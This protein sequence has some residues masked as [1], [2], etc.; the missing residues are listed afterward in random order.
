MKCPTTRPCVAVV[1]EI[2]YYLTLI[3]PK[4]CSDNLVIW[5]TNPWKKKQVLVPR[6]SPRDYVQGAKPSHE[7]QIHCKIAPE[8]DTP[9][10]KT[11]LF[12]LAQARWKRNTNNK[13]QS[14]HPQLGCFVM[15]TVS[16]TSWPLQHPTQNANVILK[17]N[18]HPLFVSKRHNWYHVRSRSGTNC[19][20]ISQQQSL[21]ERQSW[22]RQAKYR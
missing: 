18:K 2:E 4:W 9:F 13:L 8:S 22:L 15:H 10:L 17:F 7:E 19:Q 3:P 11:V 1:G 6:V 14:F 12:S 16:Q 21:S 20:S 5:W